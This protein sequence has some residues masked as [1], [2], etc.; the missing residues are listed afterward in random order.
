MR[1]DVWADITC[2][3]CYIG[4]ARFRTALREFRHRDEIEVAYRS[5]ELDPAQ[6]TGQ[7]PPRAGPAGHQ[8]RPVPGPGGRG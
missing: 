4:L 7:T 8:I 1:V 5:F 6:P 2:P 3:W